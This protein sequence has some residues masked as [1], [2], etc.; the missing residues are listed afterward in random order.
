MDQAATARNL[1]SVL[2][3]L[4]WRPA[5]VLGEAAALAQA[6]E[7]GAVALVQASAPGLG[8]LDGGD[9]PLGLQETQAVLGFAELSAGGSRHRSSPRLGFAVHQ[10]EGQPPGLF[11]GIGTIIMVT[12][13]KIP[14]LLDQSSRPR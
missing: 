9:L 4:D 13:G 5:V 7:A 12:D 3:A 11:E 14:H 1:K 10:F 6:L 2:V 8:L